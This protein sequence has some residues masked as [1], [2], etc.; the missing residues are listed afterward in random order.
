MLV[1]TDEQWKVKSAFPLDP[2]VFNQP[3]G[4]AF[5]SHQNLYISNERGQA[6]AATVLMFSYKPD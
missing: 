3:E 5:D 6:A 1:I 4:I 2:A